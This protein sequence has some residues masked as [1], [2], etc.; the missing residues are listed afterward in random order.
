MTRITL[1][2]SSQ[3]DQFK[4]KQ[5]LVDTLK[6]SV[7]AHAKDGSLIYKDKAIAT[8]DISRIKKR[9]F[10]SGK[11]FALTGGI[12]VAFSDWHGSLF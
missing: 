2:D 8:A 12:V 4:I 11:T 10:N 6:G 1:S 9:K 5:V 3:I 7:S